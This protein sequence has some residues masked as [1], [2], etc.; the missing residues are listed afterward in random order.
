M[1]EKPNDIFDPR[2]VPG[3]DSKIDTEAPTVEHALHA[4]M[5]GSVEWARSLR[6]YVPTLKI[7]EGG[8]SEIWEAV[9]VELG[10]VVAIKR[11]KTRVDKAGNSIPIASRHITMFLQEAVVAAHLEHPN[12]L[13]IYDL[14]FDTDGLPFLVMKRVRGEPWSHVLNRDF[15]RLPV[16][17]FL[18]KH[19]PILVALARAVAYAHSEGI[20]HRDLKPA[21]VMLGAFGEVLL[22]D[23]GLAMAYPRRVDDP[24]APAWLR[25]P[26]SLINRP[27]NPAGTPTYMAPEQTESTTHKLGPWTDVY[28][29]GGILYRILTG[30]PPHYGVDGND[31]FKLAQVGIVEPPEEVARE[32]ELP[33]ELVELAMKALEPE[34]ENRIQK[35]EEFLQALED[36]LIGADKQRESILLSVR[37]R[38]RLADLNASYDTI[39]ESINMLERALVLWP[40]NR[41]A[42]QLHTTA[43]QRYAQLAIRNKDLKLARVQAE[44]LPQSAEREQLL[45]EIARLEDLERQRD[46]ELAAAH[47]RVRQERDR[48][49]QLVTYL[50]GD[51]MRQLRRIGRVDILAGLCSQ[52]IAYFEK[53]ASAD[54]APS[55]VASRVRGFLHIADVHL[56][57]GEMANASEACRHALNL[58]EQVP[59][60]KI[61]PLQWELFCAETWRR[62]GSIAYHR[63]SYDEAKLAY[64][65]GCESLKSQNL[66]AGMP[67]PDKESERAQLFHGL[68]LVLWRQRRLEEALCYHIEAETIMARLCR[69]V[70]HH[71]DYV[72]VRA[73]ILATLGNVY[74]DLGQLDYAISVTQEAL[75]LREQ[76]Y[77]LDGGDILRLSHLLWVRNN[78]AL[79][80]LIKGDQSGAKSLFLANRDTARRL[81]EQDPNNLQYIRDLGFALSLAG[82]IAY[83]QGELSEARELLAEALVVAKE[84]SSRDPESLYAAGG[85]AR[86]RAQLGELLLVLDEREGAVAHL[87]GACDSANGLLE[88]APANLTLLKTWIRSTLLLILLGATQ[89]A[90]DEQILKTIENEL[91][92]LAAPSEQLDRWDNEAALALACGDT[93]KAIKLMKKLSERKWLA[94]A[95]V[96]LAR[97]RG[98][99]V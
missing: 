46:A 73:T 87:R 56:A 88:R 85:V 53:L 61:D 39:A 34:P 59:P 45:L 71:Q 4:E 7:A 97:G 72:G 15:D 58:L 24:E 78:L 8:F 82:E 18:A 23:W 48:A 28:L 77:R 1:A 62:L 21:Q 29:L 31:T 83:M 66:D 68:G 65:R 90:G 69:Q 3:R 99:P 93:Q 89:P 10:R 63:G 86:V 91:T 27:L 32:R 11:L 43:I 79:L 54:E 75:R 2:E 64:E 55:V 41:D 30:R 50:V 26:N 81:V 70:S 13:P 35:A 5:S 16:R 67:A 52:A 6:S 57:R 19:L 38:D 44:R 76:L 14:E 20:V 98:L 9:Q 51:L 22:M 25:D 47:E 33:R 92:K 49:E 12:I 37:A 74:R 40:D 94:P 60:E 42:A 95:L 36:Y 96:Q 17:A 80:L 84:V